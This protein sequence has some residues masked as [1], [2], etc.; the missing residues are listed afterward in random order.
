MARYKS[1]RSTYRFQAHRNVLKQYLDCYRLP[2]APS[3]RN[4]RFIHR[5]SLTLV[6]WTNVLLQVFPLKLLEIY[7]QVLENLFPGSAQHNHALE[8]LSAD[9]HDFDEL[10]Q[11][12]LVSAIKMLITATF[13]AEYY[14]LANLSSNRTTCATKKFLYH[15]LIR[16]F[17]CWRVTPLPVYMWSDADFSQ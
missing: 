13:L 8:L 15:L 16:P 12:V 9:Q 10:C 14:L 11:F 7:A 1:Q 2:L 3:Q 5:G 4:L 6:Y 17:Y